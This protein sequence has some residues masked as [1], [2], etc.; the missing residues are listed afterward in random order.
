MTY[1][2]KSRDYESVC[3]CDA[4]GNF[5]MIYG[6]EIV[7]SS[8]STFLST[9][10]SGEGRVAVGNNSAGE[11]VVLMCAPVSID[12]PGMED[13][14]AMV[15]ELPISYL[16]DILSLEDEDAL[17]YS[18]IIRKDGTF[19]VRN[20][21]AVRDNY[22]DRVRAVYEETD[23]Q[24]PEEYITELQAAMQAGEDYSTMIQVDGELRAASAIVCG[25]ILLTL[26]ALFLRYF[27]LNRVQV[28]ELEEAKQSAE[29]ARIA[30]E[31]AS[32][33]KG[34]SFPT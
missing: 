18:F 31:K 1:Y 5:E 19:V 30:A 10:A 26:I 29:E 25:V 21:A 28:R 2:G 33:S 27:S 4:E 9:M 6:D 17:V 13:C 12:I 7:F 16:S 11:Q 22:F 14:I 20:S 8:P 34:S 3:W 24:T 32:K 15:G 23:D